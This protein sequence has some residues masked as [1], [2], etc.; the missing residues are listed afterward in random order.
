MKR[1]FGKREHTAL[2]LA[3]DGKCENC[4]APLPLGWHADHIQP[5]S[6]GGKTEITNGQALCP[7]C[8]Q[9]K[10]NRNVKLPPWNRSLRAWQIEALDTFKR[11]Q[12]RNFLTV[13]TP[14]AGKTTFAMAAAHYLFQSDIIRQMV[15]VCPTEALKKQWA[16]SAAPFGIDINP[17]Y[18]TGHFLTSSY[19]G[20][21]I[22]YAAVGFSADLLQIL[23]SR[24]KT[25]VILDEPHHCAA[26]ANK[27][28][29]DGVLYAFEPCINRLLI[30]GT[31]YRTDRRPI[32]FVTYDKDG[33][34][35]NDYTYSYKMAL[36]DGVCRYVLFPTYEG[37]MEWLSN[38]G[39]IINATFADDLD[40]RAAS[41]RLNTAIAPDGKW[42]SLVIR[43]AHNRLVE[44]RNNGH[45]DAGGLIVTKDKAHA[46]RVAELVRT[47]TGINP[48][49]VTS[50]TVESDVVIEKF[51]SSQDPW[52]IA[53]KMVSEG[54][55][56]PRLRV[57]VYATTT[58]TELFFKQFVG[59]F[60]RVIDGLDE[61]VSSV[62]LPDE[63]TLIE[64]ARRIA[65]ERDEQID[66]FDI[67]A[68]ISDEYEDPR[69]GE[70]LPIPSMFTPISAEALHTGAIV[71]QD[72]MSVDSIQEAAQ[73][74]R[75]LKMPY[76]QPELLANAF[77]LYSA[78]H[79]GQMPNPI[80]SVQPTVTPKYRR[81][82][83]LKSQITILVN[84]YAKLTGRDEKDVHGEWL[85]PP[86][87][88]KI[89]GANNEADLKAKYAWIQDKLRK[90][91]A[92]QRND[93][94]TS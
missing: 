29:G 81:L 21:A 57:G 65:E 10:G 35:V 68:F 84:R 58:T 17:E 50:D 7:R 87:N 25:L 3:S 4:G 18:Q 63:P 54:V 72:R 85:R 5:F 76:V 77:K 32:P 80:P 16:N 53:V 83:N 12:Q 69:D 64:N 55:D 44:I 67:D 70:P 15:V 31:P 60:V 1:L 90:E 43:D 33:M 23:C 56:I 74:A 93:K 59:R 14:G 82:G 73:I 94:S 78:K 13:A 66:E 19:H 89:H 39:E 2:Y 71:D 38:T 52:I 8:N 61:Q 41:E 46:D 34:R 42:L 49:L 6:K 86:N 51:A 75:D 91:I 26:N 37:S 27:R 20:V 48:V 62:Y 9:E 30:T 36:R 24:E 88:G 47:V 45:S 28:W 79:S 11:K 22:T 92:R 40:D